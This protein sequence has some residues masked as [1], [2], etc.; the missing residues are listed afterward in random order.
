MKKTIT[1]L[2]LLPNLNAGGVE[3][4][5]IEL[6]KNLKKQNVNVIVASN[7]GRGV[8]Y[9]RAAEV[10]HIKMP[11]HKKNPLSIWRNIS[12]LKKLINEREIDIVHAHSRA[13]A[14]TG[15]YA[16]KKTNKQ[17]V[18]TFHGFHKTGWLKK[19]YNRVMS[20]GRPTIAVSKF[21][22]K[23]IIENYP[24]I[25]QK[26]ITVVHDGIDLRIFN[27][28]MVTARRQID[29]LREYNISP[30][31]KLITLVGRITG[32][33]GQHILISACAKL[34]RDDYVCVL[35]GPAQG[36]GTY[37]REIKKMINDNCLNDKIAM[38]GNV[39][40]IPTLMRISHVALNTSVRAEAFG[41][42]TLEA[43]ALGTPIIA[44][45][46]GGSLE[47]VIDGTTGF[48]VEP[49]DP[50]ALAN[51]LNKI[52][53]MSVSEHHKMGDAGV[54]QASNFSSEKMARGY[55]SAYKKILSE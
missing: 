45:K 39:T 43:S 23:Y 19:Y 28:K 21:M 47:I 17:F 4:M 1:V 12:R 38:I 33:K 41:L 22:R 25:D 34:K 5:V 51:A 27:P 31:K 29:V 35:A 40:D 48:L 44:T 49:N 32:W 2:H 50:D 53:D 8:D 18:T 26:N 24:N 10:E 7:G 16:A 15:Y 20:Y 14:W 6:S 3:R 46:I 55:L 42:T 11:L 54:A 13:P 52:L 30:D 9:L 37:F 36:N